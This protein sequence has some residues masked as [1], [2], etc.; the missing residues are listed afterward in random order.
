MGGDARRDADAVGGWNVVGEK[1]PSIRTPG[2]STL[3][4]LAVDRRA[5]GWWMLAQR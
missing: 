5:R 2:G 4:V 1:K 3:G